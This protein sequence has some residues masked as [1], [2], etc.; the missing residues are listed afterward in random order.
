MGLEAFLTQP[1]SLWRIDRF[2]ST[3]PGHAA[4]L[5][6]QGVPAHHEGHVCSNRFLR[7]GPAHRFFLQTHS[8]FEKLQFCTLFCTFFLQSPH[9]PSVREQLK[10]F[11]NYWCGVARR[12]LRTQAARNLAREFTSNLF[13][14]VGRG[15]QLRARLFQRMG[16]VHGSD[17]SRVLP[18][19]VDDRHR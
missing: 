4:D 2:P 7:H 14:S 16:V 8:P 1:R 15:H 3:F 12:D 11:E 13:T 9:S 6:G 5:R 10:N 19:T 18:E 17:C